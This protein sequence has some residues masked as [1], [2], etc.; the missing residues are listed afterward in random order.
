MS[1]CDAGF[2]LAA[3]IGTGCGEFAKGGF[4]KA[5]EGNARVT[6]RTDSFLIEGYVHIGGKTPGHSR[7]L[8]DVLNE[9]PPFLVLVDVAVQELPVAPGNEPI[10]HDTFILRKAEI[11][12][13]LPFD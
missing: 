5:G 8:S 9:P 4:V 12:F 2:W 3:S 7:R 6:I 1:I 13:A 11:K 10:H